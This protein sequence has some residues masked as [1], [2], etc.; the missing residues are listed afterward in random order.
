L[1]AGALAGCAGTPSPGAAPAPAPCATPAPTPG[2]LQLALA[3]K[4]FGR[5]LS[6]RQQL[7]ITAAGHVVDL[8]A[9]VEITPDSLV[10]VALRFDQRVLTLTLANGAVCEQRNAKLPAEV[11]GADILSDLQLAL[12]PADTIR[13]AL[14]S[15]WVLADSG[16]SRTLTHGGREVEIISFSGSPRWIG[17][18]TLRNIEYDYSLVINSVLSS[19]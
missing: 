10:L 2:R 9:V 8:D 12:W 3:P 7:Q 17:R 13:A 11:R 14:P 19:P 6:L 5:T 18:I 15:G 1:L 4:S 16:S